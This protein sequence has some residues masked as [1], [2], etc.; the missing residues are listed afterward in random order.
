MTSLTTNNLNGVW[1]TSGN[2]AFVV[3]DGGTIFF[4]NGTLWFPFGYC[5]DNNC[6]TFTGNLN[7]I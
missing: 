1:G 6:V 4:Y 2:D 3:G 5:V 7:T